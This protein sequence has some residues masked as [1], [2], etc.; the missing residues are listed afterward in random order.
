M[1]VIPTR[2]LSVKNGASLEQMRR[3]RVNSLEMSLSLLWYV[4]CTQSC[5]F[6]AGVTLSQDADG[7]IGAGA[8]WYSTIADQKHIGA[9]WVSLKPLLW[10]WWSIHPWCAC[11]RGAVRVEDAMLFEACPHWAFINL[12][13]VHGTRRELHIDNLQHEDDPTI[14]SWPYGSVLSSWW[15]LQL[16]CWLYSR[17]ANY[18]SSHYIQSKWDRPNTATPITNLP[19]TLPKGLRWSSYQ[20]HGVS[21]VALQPAWLLA[22]SIGRR[23][24]FHGVCWWL[25]DLRFL[26][27]PKRLFTSPF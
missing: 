26:V 12:Y 15:S 10:L 18:Q 19:I 22:Y 8:V 16:S 13:S 9:I 7:S 11:P 5:S 23:C 6:P 4:H 3:F 20:V 25:P 24:W 1:P 21:R 27:F 2:M 14:T 17:Q